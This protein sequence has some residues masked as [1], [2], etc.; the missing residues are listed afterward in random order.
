MGGGG[1]GACFADVAQLALVGIGA[2]L[3]VVWRLRVV[4][5]ALLE[6]WWLRIRVF[7]FAG[8]NRFECV[9]A[10]VVLGVSAMVHWWGSDVSALS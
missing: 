3:G 10:A 4:I 7:C 9:S 2:V 8:W 5:G 6:R 1:S